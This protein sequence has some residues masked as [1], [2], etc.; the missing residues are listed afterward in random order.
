MSTNGEKHC[1]NTENKSDKIAYKIFEIFAKFHMTC[2]LLALAFII[3]AVI[4]TEGYTQNNRVVFITGI[5]AGI[6]V[7]LLGIYYAIILLLY[8]TGVKKLKAGKLKGARIQGLIGAI[9][10]LIPQILILLAS[11]F[12]FYKGAAMTNVLGLIVLVEG[13]GNLIIISLLSKNLR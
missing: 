11:L 12:Y 3:I 5:A 10:L 1:M 4:T 13:I 2:I 6:Y 7:V 9:L 8:L